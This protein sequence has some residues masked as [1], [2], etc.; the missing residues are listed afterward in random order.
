MGFFRQEYWS[1]LPFPSPGDLPDPGIKPVSPVAPALQ[2]DSLPSEPPGYISIITLNVS[3][4]NAPTKRQRLTG[5]MK[6][7]ACMHF[8]L[9]HHSAW[10]THPQIVCIYFILLK[11]NHVPIMACNCNYLLFFVWLLIVKTDEHLLLLWLCNCY[12]L[13]TTA[14]WLGNRKIELSITRI[15][16]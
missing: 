13:N 4:F 2:A 14:S 16:I 15:R 11:V 8:H 10:P 12:S 3:G 9:P 6:T 1:G 5:W 7:C